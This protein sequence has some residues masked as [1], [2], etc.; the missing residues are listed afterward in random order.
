MT[1]TPG[2]PAR[3]KIGR[4]GLVLLATATMSRLADNAAAIALVLL[5]IARTGDPR[6]AGLV[7]GAFSVPTLVTGPVL[8][9]TWTGCGASGRCSPPTRCCSPPR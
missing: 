3:P 8:G 7:V 9:A 1:P 4:A 6:L 5:I 2:T